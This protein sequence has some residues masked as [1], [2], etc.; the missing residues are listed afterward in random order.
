KLTQRNDIREGA[1]VEPA[2]PGNKLL[3]KV[4]QVGDRSTEAGQPELDEHPQ[5]LERRAAG[6]D[7]HEGLHAGFQDGR[8]SICFA[9]ASR[10]AASSTEI[11][12][13]PCPAARGGGAVARTQSF[14]CSIH[15]W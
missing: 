11:P 10:S 12:I 9:S 4:A 14:F 15:R 3:A 13:L 8:R 5:H 7:R 2:A 1:L 6:T